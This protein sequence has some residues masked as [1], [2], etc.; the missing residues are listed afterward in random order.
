MRGYAWLAGVAAAGTL[1]GMGRAEEAAA[2][3]AKPV[4]EVVITAARREVLL[5]DTAEIVQVIDRRA[6][7]ELRPASTGE[8]M[9][10]ATGVAVVT[11]TGSGLPDRSVVS[12]NGLSPNY[13]LVLV[14]GVRLITD[15]IHSGQNLDFIPPSAIERIEIMRG[16]AS[17]QYGT[18]AIG[19]VVNIITRK[20]GDRP[21]VGVRG[22]VANYDTYES[23]ATAHLP[24][25]G[26]LR[27]STFFNWEESDGVPIKA[28]AHRVG[29]MGYERFNLLTRLDA[30]V[31]EQTDLFGWVNWVENRMETAKGTDD[32]RLLSPMAGFNHALTPKL[33]LSGRVAYSEWTAETN[34]E[35]NRLL[36]PETHV[37]WEAAE[38]HTLT[39]GVDYKRNTFERTAVEAPDQQTYGVFVQ[40]EW[41][42]HE[43][44]SLTPAVRYDKVDSVEGAISPKLSVLVTP[45]EELRL[46][47]SVGRGF[48]APSLQELYEEG[49]G[50]GGRAYRF[51]NPELEPEYSTTYTLGVEVAPVQAV[52]VMVYG[53][54][55][56]ID[57]MIVP[58]FRGPWAKNPAID[59][60]ER[61]NIAKARVYGGEG[62]V[63]VRLAKCLRVEGGYT[64][65]ENEDEDTGR[66]LPYSPGSSVFGKL[67][68]THALPRNL[69]L[70]GFVGAR[71]AFDREAWNWKPAAG[72]APDNP[73]GLT[74]E[75]ADYTKLDAGLAL[76]VQQRYHV[77]FKVQNILGE[78]IE[79]LDDAF[80]VLDGEPVY[81]VGLGYNLPLGTP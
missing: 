41:L 18:D 52:K 73:K 43:A 78:D 37:T 15:H 53:F 34:R 38:R 3:A 31:S 10:Y 40:D 16:A 65:T 14:D 8:L 1:A 46:R 17:A 70:T 6:I 44:L 68:T 63:Q 33:T 80:M 9:E 20:A 21:E 51:G 77:F 2:P 45:V 36:E 50:H 5:R 11:G 12:L 71:A 25:G 26:G 49:Y 35:E 7:D 62:V 19:G 13:T 47:A 4:E 28:P 66:P 72:T 81:Q 75:L 57:D 56:S 22:S 74:T 30:A 54:Y 58:V 29:K 60:W 67:V 64:W 69:E 79:N 24:L 48:H 55:S 39:G 27:L 42:A 23:G 61:T 32:S 59:V 76:N